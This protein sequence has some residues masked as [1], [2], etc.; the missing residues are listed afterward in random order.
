M[1]TGLEAA[2]FLAALA[3]TLV[4]A[5]IF[6]DRLD[7]VG[8]HLGLPEGVVGL[9]TAVAAD[10]PELSTA[11]VALATGAKS[12]GFGVVVGS[13]VFNLGAMLG[14][15]ALAAGSVTIQRDA[16]ALEGGVALGVA[17]LVVLLGFAVLPA[18]AAVAAAVVLLVPY[19]VLLWHTG[20]RYRRAQVRARDLLVF[21]P[22]VAVIVLGSVAMVHAARHIGHAAGIPDVL[23]GTLLLAVVTSLPNAHTGIRLARAHRGSAAASETFNSNTINVVGG[24]AVPALFATVAGGTRLEHADGIWFL[25]ATGVAVLLLAPGGGLRRAGGAILLASWV[26]FAVV[27]AIA[28]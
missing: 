2:S 5:A 19:L 3:V 25:A 16:L 22:A 18:W 6:A 13:N 9:L 21:P 28:S 10:A 26:A 12:V 8:E 20:Q 24:L 27:Q 17:F 23:T 4:A 11:I 7:L 1:T 15:G 14:L